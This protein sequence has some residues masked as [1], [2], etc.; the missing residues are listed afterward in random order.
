MRRTICITKPI[1][2]VPRAHDPSGLWQGSRALATPNFLSMRIVF[3]SHSQPIRF[4]R[5]D[6]KSVNRGLPELDQNRALDPCHRPEGSWALGTRM[7]LFVT[8][9]A[10]LNDMHAQLLE[11]LRPI[12]LAETWRF[13]MIQSLEFQEIWQKIEQGPRE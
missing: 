2:L 13:L 1:I 7:L 12:A 10:Q 6:R 8:E 3:A 9:R 11:K 4:V 5:F